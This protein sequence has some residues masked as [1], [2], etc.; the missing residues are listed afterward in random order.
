MGTMLPNP[1]VTALTRTPVNVTVMGNIPA[2][3]FSEK[4][5]LALSSTVETSVEVGSF[6]GAPNAA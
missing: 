4:D 3:K 5:L 6:E 2:S 1:L